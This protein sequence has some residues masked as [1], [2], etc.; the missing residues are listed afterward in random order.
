MI[1]VGP[2]HVRYFIQTGILNHTR[3]LAVEVCISIIGF[4]RYPNDGTAAIE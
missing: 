3:N 1:K 4:I 2:L